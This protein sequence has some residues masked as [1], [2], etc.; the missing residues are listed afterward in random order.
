LTDDRAHAA[1]VAE[2]RTRLRRSSWS[3]AAQGV[4]AALTRA[5]HS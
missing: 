5:A 1:A 2:G 3:D 4:L